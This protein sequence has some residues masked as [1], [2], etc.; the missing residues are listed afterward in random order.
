MKTQSFLI[1]FLL[2]LLL[3]ACALADEPQLI[4]EHPAEQAIAIYP[5]LPAPEPGHS[6]IYHANLLL[7]VHQVERTADK[8]IFFA[9][10]FDGYLVNSQSWFQGNEQYIHLVLAVPAWHFA[11]MHV[12]LLKLG[13]LQSEQISGDIISGYDTIQGQYSHFRLQLHP[14][15]NAF[16]AISLP[17]WRPI[18]TFQ[19]AWDV[20]TA[21]FGFLLDILIWVLV[22]AGPFAVAGWLIRRWVK[23]LQTR[24]PDPEN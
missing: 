13:E 9:Q 5:V 2:I 17:D 8:A 23:K 21:I 24:V 7:E 10:Q 6:I 22:V 12:E 11:D 18:Q 15:G 3:S 19:Q 20:F 1:F 4:A 16:G 14:R